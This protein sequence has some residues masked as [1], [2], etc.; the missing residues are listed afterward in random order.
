MTAVRNA[1]SA[2]A[3]AVAALDAQLF[4]LDAWSRDAVASEI[5]AADETR[6]VL[7]VGSLDLEQTQILGYA[8]VLGVADVADLL[9]IGVAVTARRRGVGTALLE[10]I[11]SHAEAAGCQRILLEVAADNASALAFY[12]RHG[13]APITR[14]PRYYPSGADAVV[15]ARALH[16]RTQS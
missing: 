11:V 14:R 4:G 12:R 8:V 2:D 10:R 16:R 9:R 5:A 7:V 1:T 6:A 15:L 3:A 13:F